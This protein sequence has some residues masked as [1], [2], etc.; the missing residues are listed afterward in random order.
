MPPD[1]GSP[2]AQGVDVSP[3][4]GLQTLSDLMNL[5]K[6]Q[7]GIQQ[8]QQNLQTGTFIQQQQQAEAQRQQAAMQTRQAATKMAQSGQ[9][10]DGNPI[11]G[12]DGEI[13]PV[14]FS[15]AL[16]KIDPVNAAPITQNII[17]TLN[18]KFTLQSGALKLDAQQ[19]QM[20]Q[21]PL[22]ALNVDPSDDNITNVRNTIG[23]LASA[24]PEMVKTA[25]AA[26]CPMVLR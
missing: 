20:L 17:K 24:H 7:I 3:N 13:D 25:N 6:T 16:N 26:S 15:T 2:I 5:Q 14:K 12:D 1:F 4:K 22:Q 9:D 23:Q 8:Q 19:R 18:D 10:L 11:R 21:G